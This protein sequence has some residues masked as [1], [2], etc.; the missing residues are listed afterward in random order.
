M[1]YLYGDLVSL[2][3]EHKFDAIA[4][5]CNCFNTMG[6]GIA[7][8]IKNEFPE[9]YAADAKTFNGHRGKLGTYT[10][11][12][13]TSGVIYNAYTQYTYWDENDMLSYDAVR[14]VFERINKDMKS[15]GITRLGIPRIGAAR[16][17]GDWGTIL[18]IIEEVC[19]DIEVYYVEYNGTVNK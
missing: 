1:K 2:F 4:H 11:V 3:K 7:L 17:G 8:T 5:G 9:A 14:L 18:G 19:T 15:K 12:D 10:T 13:T 16:A 6:A